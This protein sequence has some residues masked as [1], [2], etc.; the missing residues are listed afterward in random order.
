MPEAALLARTAARGRDG[1]DLFVGVASF[2]HVFREV[3]GF[4][5]FA[6]IFGIFNGVSR[7]LYVCRVLSEFAGVS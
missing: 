7:D 1:S 2:C 3:V 5:G 4:P 6:R